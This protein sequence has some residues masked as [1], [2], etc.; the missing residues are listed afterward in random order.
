MTTKQENEAKGNQIR[1]RSAKETQRG[2]YCHSQLLDLWHQVNQYIL[3]DLRFGNWGTANIPDKS[4]EGF[5]GFSSL[6]EL[7][8]AFRRFW[9]VWPSQNEK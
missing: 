7:Y 3:Q 2:R 9:M 6:S 5:I 1:N 8:P 4:T